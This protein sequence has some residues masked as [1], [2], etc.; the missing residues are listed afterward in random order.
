MCLKFGSHF[1]GYASTAA[2]PGNKWYLEEVFIRIQ[3]E[4]RHFR[5]AVDQNG[6]VPDILVQRRR[7]GA[8]TNASL[9]TCWKAYSIRPA[10]W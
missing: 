8:A 2:R 9:S 10:S 5:R 3:G 6:I 1:A 4:L 7:D